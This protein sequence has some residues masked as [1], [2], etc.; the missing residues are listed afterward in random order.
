MRLRGLR[1]ASVALFAICIGFL[2][3]TLPYALPVSSFEPLHVFGKVRTVSGVAHAPVIVCVVAGLH[4]LFAVRR[5]YQ[6]GAT[7]LLPQA[8]SVLLTPVLVSTVVSL[9]KAGTTAIEAFGWYA[10][11]C[12][13]FATA[14]MAQ[15]LLGS[16]RQPKSVGPR[17]PTSM[18]Y[19]RNGVT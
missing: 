8:A 10:L 12:V 18:S 5:I 1:Y 9:P 17:A 13:P 7:K 15:E 11:W 16:S 14:A 2:G 3:V 6:G 4:V 19:C